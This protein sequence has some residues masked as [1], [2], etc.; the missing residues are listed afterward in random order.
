MKRAKKRIVTEDSHGDQR[1]WHVAGDPKLGDTFHHYRVSLPEGARRYECSCYGSNYGDARRAKMCSHVLAVV[2]LRRSEG[3]GSGQSQVSGPELA[4][5]PAT[6]APEVPET[7]QSK[8]RTRDSRVYPTSPQ[9]NP[10]G[11]AQ[12]PEWL[13][14]YR[15]H[16]EDAI[17]E[18]VEQFRHHQIVYLNAPTGSGKTAIADAVARRL[19]ERGLYVCSGLQL[20]E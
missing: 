10:Q 3:G 4:P 2:L 8:P 5:T 6:K 16:Q 11:W 13:T 14:E 20:Q 15:P 12:P 18:V 9:L 1:Y 17:E 19:R 7:T